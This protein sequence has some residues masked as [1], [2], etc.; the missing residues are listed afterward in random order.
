MAKNLV[1]LN[2]PF[3]CSTAPRRPKFYRKN[4][5]VLRCAAALL[6]LI[7]MLRSQKRNLR[8]KKG[9]NFF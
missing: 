5:A 1:D 2:G 3:F 7:L 8:H 4:N 6:L 9:R